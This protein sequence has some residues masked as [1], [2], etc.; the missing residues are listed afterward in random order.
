M[1]ILIISIYLSFI[2]VNIFCQNNFTVSLNYTESGRNLCFDYSRSFK[3]NHSVGLG[4]RINI[5]SI[6][7][8][9][10]QSNFFYKRLYAT[11]FYQFF[12]IHTFYHRRIFEKWNCFKPYIFYDLQLTKSTTRSSIY[13]PYTYSSTGDVLYKNYIEYFGPFVWLEQNIG[14]GFNITIYKSLSLVEKFGL[15][16][17]LIFGDDIH[18]PMK[19]KYAEF[20]LGALLAFGLS[21]KL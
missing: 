4:L 8:P 3:E 21:M 15:G 19:S 12:G 2:A 1:K 14:F 9:D 5:N 16:Y 13:S 7:Q 20:D 17:S 6:R 18:L 10:D 11:E